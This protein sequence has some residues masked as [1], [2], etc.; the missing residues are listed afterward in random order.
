VCVFVC[1][2]F[3]GLRAYA[4]GVYMHVCEY[5]CFVK[6]HLASLTR[7]TQACQ[8]LKLRRP[9]YVYL[10][11]N[12]RSLSINIYTPQRNQNKRVDIKTDERPKN[13]CRSLGD[14]KD[15]R[16]LSGFSFF[17]LIFAR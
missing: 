6:F 10:Q 9:Y 15:S 11:Y 16:V 1:T 12:Y 7:E 17:F 8:K 3:C 13:R 4:C 2:F 5:K 14:F